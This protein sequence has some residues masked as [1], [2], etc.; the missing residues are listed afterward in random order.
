VRAR[1]YT[2]AMPRRTTIALRLLILPVLALAAGGCYQRVVSARG[3]GADT[4]NVQR[5]N[6]PDDSSDRTLGYKTVT[7]K[8]IPPAGGSR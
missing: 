4:T 2:S 1:H 6:L 5:G 3:F 7:P 8:P